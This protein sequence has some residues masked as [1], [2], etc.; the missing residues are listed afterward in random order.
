[1]VREKEAFCGWAESGPESNTRKIKKSE[2][3]T[4]KDRKHN[5][6]DFILCNRPTHLKHFIKNTTFFIGYK[7]ISNHFLLIRFISLFCGNKF[8]IF[9]I[10]S[11]YFKQIKQKQQANALK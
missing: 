9:E 6:K 10:I 3:L 2:I 1:M 11:F 4:S 5:D 7:K 8:Q